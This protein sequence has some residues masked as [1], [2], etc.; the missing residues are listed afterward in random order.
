[1]I[2]VRF[3]LFFVVCALIAKGGCA[4]ILAWIPRMASMTPQDGGELVAKSIHMSNQ[5]ERAPFFFW[6]IGG[7]L[8]AP[9]ASFALFLIGIVELLRRAKGCGR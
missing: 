7:P 9:M 3:A 2:F 4:L 8:I 5:F 6:L 1:M